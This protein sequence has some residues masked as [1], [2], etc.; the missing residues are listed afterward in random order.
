MNIFLLREA[1]KILHRTRL[2]HI[3]FGD[4]NLKW[5]LKGKAHMKISIRNT[6]TGKYL[7]R[8]GKWTDNPDAAQA[9]PDEERAREYFA[10]RKLPNIEVVMLGEPGDP[11]IP[12]LK[13]SPTTEAM[14]PRIPIRL[15]E[16]A[17]TAEEETSKTGPAKVTT[18][19]PVTSASETK[20]KQIEAK[21]PSTEIPFVKKLTV[22]EAK[23]DVGFG[24]ALFIRGKG[25]GLSWERGQP[26]NCIN[27]TTWVWASE[28]AND[29]AVFKL[30][31]N[32]QV[33]SQGGDLVVEPGKVIAVAPAF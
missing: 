15:A 22:V 26:L 11:E 20:E 5:L 23:V 4:E 25:A 32:D 29:N 30:L 12:A 31:L 18:A 1:P 3:V 27:G 14:R 7:A 33:W 19:T 28:E 13:P 10:F 17:K 16:Q 21:E 2:P 6:K 8:P 24:N 9:F